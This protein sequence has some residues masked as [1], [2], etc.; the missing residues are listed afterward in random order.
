MF[1]DLIAPG[2]GCLWQDRNARE[3]HRQSVQGLFY[4]ACPVPGLGRVALAPTQCPFHIREVFHEPIED[5]PGLGL[6]DHTASV[7]L[8]VFEPDLSRKGL[9]NRLDH[10]TSEESFAPFRFEKPNKRFFYGPLNHIWGLSVGD[11]VAAGLVNR[12]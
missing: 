3:G 4:F 2:L 12:K 9:V 6:F 7:F 5:I 11:S 8:A 1:Q 10:D